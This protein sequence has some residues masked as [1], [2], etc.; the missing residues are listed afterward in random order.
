MYV[1]SQIVKDI[2]NILLYYII[3]QRVEY[4]IDTENHL[5]KIKRTSAE[6]HLETE[7]NRLMQRPHFHELNAFIFCDLNF[8]TNSRP[9]Y[10][11]L[12][13]ATVF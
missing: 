4:R 1:F 8:H 13:L 7:G 2:D 11:L 12:K 6:C 3:I 9:E 5:K 10:S